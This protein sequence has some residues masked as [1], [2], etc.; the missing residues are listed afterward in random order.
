MSNSIKII[1]KAGAVKDDNKFSYVDF[2]GK[3]SKST[4]DLYIEYGKF[5]KSLPITDF[6]SN[7]DT[8]CIDPEDTVSIPAK[9]Y[10]N[11]F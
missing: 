9:K 8:P 7:A 2:K 11:V 6:N 4:T 3:T 10:L 5:A 1:K